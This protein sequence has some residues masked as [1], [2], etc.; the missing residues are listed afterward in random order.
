MKKRFAT[1]VITL[2]S[3]VTLAACAKGATEDTKLVTMKGDTIT[4]S[5]FYNEVK[6]SAAAQQAMLTLVL[7]RVFEEQFGDQVSE[8]EVTEA[9][10]KT[11]EQYGDNFANALAG[12]GLT[13]E[14]YKQELRKNLLLE[15]AVEEA[16]KKEI[17]DEVLQKAYESY[18]PEVKAQVIALETEED[19]K[20]VLEEVKK[21]GADFAAI[22]KD[23]T[24]AKE[25]DYTFDSA[26]TNLP[27]E[28]R[29]A[30]AKLDVNAISE[31]VPVVNQQTF[32]TAY[33]I[34][35]TT[36]K[37]EKDANWQTYKE[38]LNTI[39]LAEKKA[40]SNLQKSVVAAALEKANVKIKDDAF[41]NILAV[42]A[43]TDTSA[44]SS[45]SEASTE[46][47]STEASSEA[48]DSSSSGQ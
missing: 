42:Y 35:K 47:S 12:V 7:S 30:A 34:V 8:E 18:T 44:S 6:S 41:A 14:T 9:Y 25:V 11:S 38:R 21:D 16:A 48:T 20:A 39:V 37:A 5:D 4:V 33:Y 31:V 2:L 17:T 24:K 10:N 29:E 3:V 1:G 27:A 19:A 15:H 36:A 28:V 43:T 40:D 23:K 13:P 22:A 46:E 45:S 32:T 26:D